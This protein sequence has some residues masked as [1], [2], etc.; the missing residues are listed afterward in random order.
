[1]P[2]SACCTWLCRNLACKAVRASVLYCILRRAH[3]VRPTR[4]LAS[5]HSCILRLSPGVI[6][7]G[8]AGILWPGSPY[9]LAYLLVV[10]VVRVVDLLARTL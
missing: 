3:A 10:V 6:E 4:Q 1:M 8:F 7:L 5:M 9:S 2:V